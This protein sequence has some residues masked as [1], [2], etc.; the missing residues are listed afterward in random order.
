MLVHKWEKGGGCFVLFFIVLSPSPL[1]TQGQG[2]FKT[3]KERTGE[4]SIH[5]MLNSAIKVVPQFFQ[6]IK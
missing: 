3:E 4:N 5:W 1:P 2:V 6:Q